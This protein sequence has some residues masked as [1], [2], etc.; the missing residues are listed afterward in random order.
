MINEKFWN[1]IK[2]KIKLYHL[3]FLFNYIGGNF[4]SEQEIKF[5]E[6][7]LGKDALNWENIPLIEQIFAIGKISQKIGLKNTNKISRKDV[8]DWIKNNKNLN[9]KELNKVKA[10]TYLDTLGKQF[11]I[12]K[13]LRQ[14]VLSKEKEGKKIKIS[15]IYQSLKNKFE[16]WA[17][18]KNSILYNSE[19]ALNT[20]K[21]DEAKDIKLTYCYKVPI[22]DE[23]L[24]SS[25]KQA[26]LN[27]DGS[28]RIYLVSQLEGYG[29]NIGKKQ[30]DWKP[31]LS[32]LHPHCRCLLQFL[33]VLPNTT[34]EDYEWNGSIYALKENKDKK[35]SRI[36]RKSKVK[37]TIG[38]KEFEV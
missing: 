13:D 14:E 33:D 4:L 8:L 7:E 11:S 22:K 23:K 32:P 25:C 17:N 26:Y 36:K 10:Q 18:L 37:I 9:L 16:D 31:T 35:D 38:S 30:I 27:S 5:L 12:E 3:N 2:D 24:C 1:K 15:D 34:L 29:S 28:P 6:K 19:D 21:I 20:G